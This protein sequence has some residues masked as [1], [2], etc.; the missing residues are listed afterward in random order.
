MSYRPIKS[1][2]LVRDAE[3][4]E[5]CGTCSRLIPSFIRKYN[6]RLIISE[7]NMRQPEVKQAVQDVV[8][9]CAYDAISIVENTR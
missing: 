1:Y 7:S 5:K 6:G 4:C 3:K 2:F 8:D 9:A